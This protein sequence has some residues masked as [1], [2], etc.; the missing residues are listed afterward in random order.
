MFSYVALEDRIAADHLLSGV[1][2]SVDAVLAQMTGSSVARRTAS[3]GQVL[4]QRLA[5]ELSGH[6]CRVSA[7]IDEVAEEKIDDSA[8]DHGPL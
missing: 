8:L 3:L 1:R 4:Q 7:G 2:A 6:V 5:K